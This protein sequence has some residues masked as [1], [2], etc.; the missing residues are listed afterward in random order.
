VKFLGGR[1][2]IYNYMDECEEWGRGCLE[3][4]LKREREGKEH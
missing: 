3:D 2:S 1:G 4:L